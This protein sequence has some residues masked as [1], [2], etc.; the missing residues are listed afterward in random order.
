MH[1]RQGIGVDH[2]LQQLLVR[3]LVRLP[4]GSV[5]CADHDV[6]RVSAGRQAAVNGDGQARV[7]VRP[8]LPDEPGLG[9]LVNAGRVLRGILGSL[10]CVRCR[11]RTALRRLGGV[12]CGL[13]GLLGILG[14]LL[15]RR[16][17][18]KAGRAARRRA[19]REED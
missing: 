6:P 18:R 2:R 14:A 5:R 19:F 3:Q 8:I 15:G 12:L 1:R 16:R 9:L 17:E 11:I 13:L 7:P 10:G 4:L